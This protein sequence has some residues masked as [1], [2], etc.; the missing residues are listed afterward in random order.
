MATPK[1]LAGR[2]F[3]GAIFPKEFTQEVS[4]QDSRNVVVF[5]WDANFYYVT[6]MSGNKIPRQKFLKAWG[7]DLL[8]QI[9]WAAGG[10]KNNEVLLAWPK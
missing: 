6:N 3:G 4:I 5:G 9:S 7:S 10:E 8:R 2:K 1:L